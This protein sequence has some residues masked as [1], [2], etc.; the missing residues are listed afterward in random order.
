MRRPRSVRATAAGALDEVA[1]D[2]LAVVDRGQ[3]RGVAEEGTEL[4]GEVERQRGA[5]EA[6]AMVDADVRIEAG[7][8]QRRP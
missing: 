3:D 7:G 1:G 6:G 2:D 5:A 8:E 4:L